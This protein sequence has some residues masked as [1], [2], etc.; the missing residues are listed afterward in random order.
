M[1]TTVIVRFRAR[2]GR[3]ADLLSWL[4]ANQPGLRAFRGFE[5]IA[6]HR[7]VADPDHVIEI[8]EWARADDHRAMVEEVAARG[9]WDALEALLEREPETTYLEH[10]VSLA[11]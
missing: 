5:R 11:T 3:G 1:A 4:S 6:L 10:V 7:D 9:G 2:S 8:E